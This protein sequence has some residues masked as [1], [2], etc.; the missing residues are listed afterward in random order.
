AEAARKTAE[1]SL[2]SAVLRAPFDAR[3]SAQF[4]EA[5]EIAMA[6]SPILELEGL[7]SGRELVV[8]LPEEVVERVDIGNTF[9]LEGMDGTA[10]V[11][12]IGSRA[13]GGATFPVTLALKTQQPVL[14]GATRSVRVQYRAHDRDVLIVPLGAVA[15]GTGQ[16]G[17]VFVYDKTTERVAARAVTIERYRRDGVEITGAL[18]SGDII[19]SRGAAFLNDGEPVDL[20][21]VGVARF[22]R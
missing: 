20:L 13:S 18:A 9:L 19:A 3:V 5:S 11:A 4:K 6:G 14:V 1:D 8:N 21:G 16:A 15:V 10:V 7:L 12:E 17:T 22:E 2:A